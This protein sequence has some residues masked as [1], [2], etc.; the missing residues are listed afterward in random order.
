VITTRGFQCLTGN[1]AVYEVS[2]AFPEGMSGGPVLLE[3]RGQLA[4]VGV[5]LGVDVVEYGA[6]EQRVGIA[7]IGD[8]ILALESEKL[9]GLFRSD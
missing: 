9:G 3:V 1:P 8:E 2:C 7:M 6:V 4:V 5:V